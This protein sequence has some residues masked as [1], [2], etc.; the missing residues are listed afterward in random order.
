MQSWSVAMVV[1]LSSLLVVVGAFG[2]YQMASRH[3]LQTERDDAQAALQAAMAKE[4][5]QVAALAN[6]TDQLATV[7]AQQEAKQ[8]AGR[9]YVSG[10]SAAQPAWSGSDADADTIH[11]SFKGK[12]WSIQ[13]GTV[14]AGLHEYFGGMQRVPERSGHWTYAVNPY[15]DGA[16]HSLAARLHALAYAEHYNR[17][18]ESNF[19]LA[20]VQA[21]PHVA[22]GIDATQD[23]Y[24]KF[25]VET[26]VD[27]G[28]DSEDTS[29]LYAALMNAIGYH[30]ALL[31]FPGHTM[32]GVEI[33]GTAGAT[34]TLEGHPFLLAETAAGGW[35]VGQ[36]PRPDAFLNS[37]LQGGQVI[38][39]APWV[40]LTNVLSSDV[41]GMHRSDFT[42]FNWGNTPASN[43]TAVVVVTLGNKTLETVRC[44]TDVPALATV[45]CRA[46]VG[47][48]PRSTIHESVEY[49]S[50]IS[51]TRT[52]TAPA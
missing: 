41:D 11:W 15:G 4:K 52:R 37:T 19:I 45:T 2:G 30:V 18:N 5:L 17:L 10:V 9:G 26:L 50:T 21:L 22:D 51:Y 44:S 31:D 7:Q 39:D 28:G 14:N 49:G 33:P 24:T 38:Q 20:A 6:V 13:L 1:G 27:G 32:A 40:G 42:F 8:T 16:V 29:V 25:P 34:A 3:E 12:S 36:N 43:V 23:D 47:S 48:V 35:T 46:E